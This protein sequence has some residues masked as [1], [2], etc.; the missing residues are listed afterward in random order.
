V[1]RHGFERLAPLAAL[2]DL[3][4]WS[5]AERAALLRWMQAKGAS[6]EQEFARRATEQ[7]RFFRALRE[8]GRAEERL[9]P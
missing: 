7:V 8:V 9:S 2:L 3:R 1:D 4:A 6:V 5:T